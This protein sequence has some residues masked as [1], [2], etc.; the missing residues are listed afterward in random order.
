VHELFFLGIGWPGGI[1]NS[2]V[3]SK[4]INPEARKGSLP[5]S[6]LIFNF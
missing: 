1:K 4:K 5:G 3:K 2:K 6:F